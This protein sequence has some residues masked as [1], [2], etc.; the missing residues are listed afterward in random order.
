MVRTP[1]GAGGEALE[2]LLKSGK[3]KERY[4]MRRKEESAPKD[5][6]TPMAGG[7][8]IEDQGKPKDEIPAE[9]RKVFIMDNGRLRPLA[10]EDYTSATLYQIVE[11]YSV[12]C[13]LVRPEES[14]NL[15]FEGKKPSKKTVPV[16]VTRSG[17]TQLLD[18]WENLD[19][20]PGQLADAVEVIGATP[21]RQIFVLRR[22]E[23]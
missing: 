5:K 13:R 10:S 14:A 16:I 7:N 21:V 23:E 3:Y 8:E 2:V 1:A 11:Q 19:S 12:E 15:I 17:D 4:V 18:S 22:K 6:A 9:D 20:N